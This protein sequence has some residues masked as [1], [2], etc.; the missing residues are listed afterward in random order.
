MAAPAALGHSGGVD[1][2]PGPGIPYAVGQ[3]KKKKKVTLN[4]KNGCPRSTPV[5]DGLF[6][7]QLIGRRRVPRV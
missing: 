7:K 3:P 5:T 6:G 1:L 4:L 2:I